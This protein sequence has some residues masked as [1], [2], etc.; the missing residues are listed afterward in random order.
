MFFKHFYDPD[1]AQGSYLIGC[2]ASGEAVVV[3]PRRDVDVYLAEAAAQGLTITDVTETHI[4]ADYL[5]GT[6]EL[7]DRTGARTWLSDEGDADWKYGFEG[8]KLYDGSEIHVGNVVLRAVHTPGHTPEHLSFLVIDGATS[9]EPLM[10]LTGDFVFVGDVGRPDLLD[11][12]AGGEDT[13]F[14]GAKDLFASLRD[15]FLTL[16]DHIQV[17]P[18]HGAGSACG[19]ALG[20]VPTT[21]V[22]YERVASWWAG[23]VQNGDEAGFTEELLEGQPDAPAYFG[24][25]K[26]WNKAGPAVLGERGT[27][28]ELDGA[29]VARRLAADEILFLDTRTM[30]EWHADGV[31]GG[32]F[33]PNGTNFATYASYAIDPERDTQGIVVLAADAEQ[34]AGLRDKLAYTGI[35]AFEGYVT[36]LDALP[37]EAKP[38]LTPEAFDGRDDL[39]ILDTRTA[40]EA[41]P[42]HF[43]GSVQIHSGRVRWRADELPRDAGILTHCVSGGRSAVA[44]SVLRH[45][46]YGPVYELK[47]SWVGWEQYQQRKE[48]EATPA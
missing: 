17:W 15:R 13:R 36:S 47:G 44:A 30:A 34:A 48:A 21:T 42:E 6:R 31:V 4:H 27:P 39:V 11:E 32:L 29:D 20:S 25:M 9:S 16:P 33:V 23:Y 37:R 10:I 12:A 19:K 2:Q 35:D 18:A 28:R 46:G 45:L 40:T 3:D 5:S 26:R 24:R 22:G 1:L 7:A 41:A 14:A 8:E 38:I 43:D